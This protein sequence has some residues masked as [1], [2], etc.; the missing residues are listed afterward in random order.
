MT[1]A[2]AVLSRAGVDELIAA[3]IAGGYRVVGPT[4]RDDAIVLA[5]L[6]SGDQLPSGW[7]VETS[8]DGTGCAAAATWPCSAIRPD[9]NPGSSSCIRRAGS[10]GQ[11]AATA[12]S[13]P[14]RSLCATRFSASGHATSPRSQSWPRCR[15]S[16]LWEQVANRCLTCG[17]CTMVCFDQMTPQQ[18]AAVAAVAREVTFETGT[19]LFE[20]GQPASGCWLIRLGQVAL[21]TFVPGA[22]HPG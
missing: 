1:E 21:Q 4:V 18:R 8:P 7:G 10:C 5:E 17:N 11:P 3:L 6:S 13:R 9:R 19:M 16:P 2:A 15:D 12:S 20:E 22:D 14:S